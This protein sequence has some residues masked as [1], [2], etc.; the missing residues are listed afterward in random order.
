MDGEDLYARKNLRTETKVELKNANKAWMQC[1]EKNFMKQWMAGSDVKISDVCVDEH[2][3][4][5]E[6]DAEVY[7]PTPYKL[8]PSINDLI[9]HN[10]DPNVA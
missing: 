10:A 1:L 6:L 8:V 4:M 9:K 2:N 3:R 5:M 7:E